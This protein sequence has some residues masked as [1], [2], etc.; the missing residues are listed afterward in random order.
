VVRGA[1]DPLV[2]KDFVNLKLTVKIYSPEK[3]V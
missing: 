1:N 2:E 3:Y